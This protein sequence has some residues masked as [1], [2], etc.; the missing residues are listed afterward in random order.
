MTHR[1][2]TPDITSRSTCKLF[3]ELSRDDLEKA[4]RA[5]NH[6][7]GLARKYGLTN[8]DIGDALGITEARVRAILAGV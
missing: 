6:Y 8:Q 5:R 4:K 2:N 3:L 7:I 1:I